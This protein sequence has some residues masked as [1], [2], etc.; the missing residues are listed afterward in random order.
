MKIHQNNSLRKQSISQNTS[1][2]RKK[3]QQRNKFRIS[4]RVSFRI[5]WVIRVAW[6]KRVNGLCVL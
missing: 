2:E 4:L 5:F 3:E 6:N 1:A